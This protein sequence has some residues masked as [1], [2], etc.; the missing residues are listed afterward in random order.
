MK[1]RIISGLIMVPLLLVVVLGGLWLRAAVFL[2]A[3]VGIAEFFRGFQAMGIRPS[4]PAAAA[5][6]VLLYVIDLLSSFTQLIPVGMKPYLYVLWLFISIVLCMLY[7]FRIDERTLEDGMATITGIVYIGFFSYHAVLVDEIFTVICGITPVWLILITAFCTDIGAYFGGYFLGK[8]KLCP[9]ISPQK[10]VEGAVAGAL[11]SLLICLVFALIFLDHRLL[12]AYALLGLAGG[13][14][15]QLGDLTASIF[16]RK[17]GIKDYG[18]L[19]PGHGGIM[20]RFDS[21][22]FTA[23]L[24]FYC[25]LFMYATRI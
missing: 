20:D 11:S 13:V 14:F 12:P 2:I 1:Q 25:M 10:T 16:K 17:M 23:P 6:M 19:I 21:V 8:R 3:M 9:V 22:L 4:Y 7:L 24:V 15:S 18:K 5:S